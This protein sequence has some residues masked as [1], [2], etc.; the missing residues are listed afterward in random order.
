MDARNGLCTAGLPIDMSKRAYQPPFTPTSEIISLVARIAEQIG[1]LSA[2]A[3]YGMDLRLRRINRI[4]SIT[5]S[6]AIEGN[7]LSEEQI[8]GI[9]EG[10]TVLAPPR[11]LQEARNA[12]AVYEHLSKWKGSSERDLLVAHKQL[13]RGLLDHPGTY[14]T[15]GIGVMAGTR[16]VHMAPPAN[17]VPRLM[18]QLFDW[19][20]STREHPLI[21]S[22]VF[23]YE[24]EFIHPFADGNG[25]MGR[26]WQTL[27]L[28]EWQPAFAWL[29][30]E[31]LVHQRQD[32]YYRAINDSTAASDCAPFVH[33]MLDRIHDAV[34][35][36][37]GRKTGKAIGKTTGKKPLG[38]PEAILKLLGKRPA[39]TVP[40]LAAELGKA[41]ITIHRAI[42]ILRESGRLERV[43][44]DKGG[45]WRVL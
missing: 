12:L 16:V 43:G 20:K 3:N 24:F 33:F 29:P 7:S 39:L 41:E 37:S 36:A 26:L 27:I 14:R 42:R 2:Q 45:K 8:T 28:S 25:R 34:S 31:S 18:G 44:P 17:R 38:T 23:H 4:R 6:L 10:K 11:E 21:A 15:S 40:E 30:V 32:R 35:K 9:L 13:M 5:G 22:S 19:L 1:R